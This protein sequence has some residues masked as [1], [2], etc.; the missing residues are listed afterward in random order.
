MIKRVI[1][2]EVR[3]FLSFKVMTII[4]LSRSAFTYSN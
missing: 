2:L 1:D 4:P 3:E